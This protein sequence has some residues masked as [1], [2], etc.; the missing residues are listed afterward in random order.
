L[1]GGVLA[2]DQI[3]HAYLTTAKY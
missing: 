1:L 3:V 2:V